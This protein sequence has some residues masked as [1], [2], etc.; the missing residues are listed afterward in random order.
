MASPLG[1]ANAPDSR[2]RNAR[3]GPW[4]IAPVWAAFRDEV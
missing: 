1:A 3:Y 2:S 4:T